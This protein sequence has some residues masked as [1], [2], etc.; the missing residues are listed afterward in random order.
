MCKAIDKHMSIDGVR[1][2]KKTGGTKGDF[3]I[4]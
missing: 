4:A 2:V 1:L 3:A